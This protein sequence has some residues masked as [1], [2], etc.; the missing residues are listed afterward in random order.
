MENSHY[1]YLRERVAE[2][3]MWLPEDKRQ[4]AA[5]ATEYV[6]PDPHSFP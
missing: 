6:E 5:A 2:K 1:L 3:A 4:A